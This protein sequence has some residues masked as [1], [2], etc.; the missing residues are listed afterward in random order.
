MQ[1]EQEHVKLK[2]SRVMLVSC[3]GGA[4]N[5]PHVGLKR[6]NWSGDQFDQLPR[7]EAL[8][9]VISGEHHP[10]AGSSARW[11]WFTTSLTSQMV[12]GSGHSTMAIRSHQIC[13]LI[14]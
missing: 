8:G 12:G 10:S 14:Y 5:L 6:P 1:R 9:K 2:K 4:A 11:F 13:P 3:S 7:R